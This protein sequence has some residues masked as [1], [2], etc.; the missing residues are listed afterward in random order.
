MVLELFTRAWH[1]RM[2]Q[3][4]ATFSGAVYMSWLNPSPGRESS[5]GLL[6]DWQSLRPIVRDA[7]RRMSG[8]YDYVSAAVQPTGLLAPGA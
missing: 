7:F 4:Y 3:N 5:D 8:A 2:Y 6:V 1:L